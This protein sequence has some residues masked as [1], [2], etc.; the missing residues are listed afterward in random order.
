MPKLHEILAVEADR[1]AAAVA[2]MEETQV[3]FNKRASH[4]QGHHKKFVSFEEGT[5]E[6]DEDVLEIVD[7]VP[8]KL[9]HAFKI[10]ARAID[11]TATKDMTNQS[12]EARA[13]V[14]IDGVAITDPLPATTLLMLE[15]KVKGMQRLFLEIPTLAPGRRWEKD[16]DKGPN[17]YR[18]ANPSAKFRTKKTVQHKVLVDPTEHHPA[19]IERWSEDEKIGKI[20]ETNWSAMM[21]PA[22]KSALLARTQNLLSAIKQAR[23]RA[24]CAEVTQVRVADKLFN[25]LLPEG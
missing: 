7:T 20:V 2:V 13:A 8:D 6:E 21:S 11:V 23:M 15:A 17:V 22:E 14:E 1:D 10:A 9:R 24:N 16:P 25:Y 18:D 3:T 4:F 19:Q 5:P 12:P